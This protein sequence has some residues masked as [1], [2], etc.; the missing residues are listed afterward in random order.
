MFRSRFLKKTLNHKS[1]LVQSIQA[2][3]FFF[4]ETNTNHFG[5]KL[6]SQSIQNHTRNSCKAFTS[7]SPSLRRLYC[8]VSQF[9]SA[10]LQGFNL[11]YINLFPCPICAQSTLNELKIQQTIRAALVCNKLQ[12]ISSNSIS[13]EKIR[14][15]CTKFTNHKNLFEYDSFKL[16]Q[17]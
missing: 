15:H 3:C 8:T 17:Q 12:L 10:A 16:P 1:E 7:S 13:H 2:H 9:R 11:E 4:F 6:C 5:C 14:R